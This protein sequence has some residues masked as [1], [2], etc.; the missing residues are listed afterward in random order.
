ML[1]L[2]WIRSI[3]TRPRGEQVASL[4]DVFET[5]TL[6][7]ASEDRKASLGGVGAASF[8]EAAGGVVSGRHVNTGRL[9]VVDRGRR[10]PQHVAPRC[11]VDGLGT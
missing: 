10:R 2:S 8:G 4:V 1:E 5:R 3:S 6:P 9:P 11:H 7:G